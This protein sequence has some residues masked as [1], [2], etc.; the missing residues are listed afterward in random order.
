MPTHVIT[1]NNV[2]ADPNTGNVAVVQTV[3]SL[4]TVLTDAQIKALN[5][6]FIELVPDV[7]EGK[8]PLLI[9]GFIDFDNSA[10]GYSNIDETNSYLAITLKK[11]A[12]LWHD[13]SYPK[14]NAGMHDFVSAQRKFFYF[15]PR[16]IYSEDMAG[17]ME[18]VNVNVS[19]ANISGSGLAVA[20]YNANGDLIG[21]NAGNSM[22]IT[23]V[24]SIV[25][26]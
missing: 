14:V 10:G 4:K 12:D 7:P 17:A 26:L 9:S 24:Y 6:T 11:G 8:S 20:M 22:S 19:A 25:D 23:V 3:Y 16:S 5:T 15:L 1:A 2:S 13:L 21:G 18:S